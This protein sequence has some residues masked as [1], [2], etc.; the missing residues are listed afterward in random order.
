MVIAATRIYIFMYITQCAHEVTVYQSFLFSFDLIFL[1][2]FETLITNEQYKF[3]NLH[4][5]ITV[6][7]IFRVRIDIEW[8][9]K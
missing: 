2:A 8:S 5:N 1:P 3:S 6:F 4:C 7:I 9:S